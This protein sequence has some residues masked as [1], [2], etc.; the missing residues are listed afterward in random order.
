MQLRAEHA[1]AKEDLVLLVILSTLS[2]A[3]GFGYRVI[4]SRWAGAEVM[5]LYQLVMPVYSLLLSFSAVGAT[6]A[7]SNLTAQHL[8]FQNR[9]A[10]YQ[11]RN[12]CLRF[13][14]FLLLPVGTVVIVCSDAI[15]VTL[16]GD[17]RT[18]LGLILL[19][20]CTALTGIENL[21]KHL[22]YGS[23]RI[24]PPAW[25]E[26][27]EQLIRA[28][29]VLGLLALF[30]PQYPER[31]VGLIVSGM[32]LCEI[33]SAATLLVLYHRQRCSWGLSGPGEARRVRRSRV[34][35]IALPVGANA[36]LGNLMSAATSA[37]IPQLLMKSG[38][39]RSDAM[40]QLGVVCGMTMPM[41]A[42]P[43]FFLGPLSLMVFPRM[44][45]ANALGQTRQVKSLLRRSLAA[46]AF[47][48]LPALAFMTVLGEELACLL[49]DRA[50]AARFL[51]PLSLTVALSAF[52]N[53]LC[54]GLNAIGHQGQV[55]L[56]SFGGNLL[57]L[58]LLLA[59]VP[60]PGI[61]MA[62][63]AAAT[64]VSAGM[65]FLTALF[66][67]HRHSALS[68]TCFSWLTAPALSALLAGLWSNL[69]FRYLRKLLF[70]LPLCAMSTLLFGGFLYLITMHTLGFHVRDLLGKKKSA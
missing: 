60:L 32:I 9:L 41:L 10:V 62:G 38:L 40:S 45:R 5:G 17:A 53:V 51:L 52:C 1:P 21:H 29:A 43:T 36:V 50:D 23:G 66:L 31:V 34:A 46:T 35:A 26:F 25:V 13:F 3:L 22:F 48:T 54:G 61:G 64:L 6:S 67:V 69:L 11:T 59:L 27:L 7:I 42:L 37:L 24:R 56:L 33:F 15:S 30:L 2:Q 49:F 63:Y 47:F 8:A 70:P 14:A 18:Q 4:L 12:T 55:A 28:A 20:P 16:L 65:E 39:E 57:Q 19:V 58:L 44:A 68:G